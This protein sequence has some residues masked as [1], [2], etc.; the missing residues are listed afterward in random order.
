MEHLGDG[1][2]AFV[3]EVPGRAMLP[4]FLWNDGGTR[5]L[6]S[7][8]AGQSDYCDM[9]G[10]ADAFPELLEAIAA[11]PIRFDELLLP[12]L[13]PGSAL[14]GPVPRGWSARE[15]THEV[16]PVL[17]L[18]PDL[19]RS[20]RRKVVHDR[21]RAEALGGVS[22][23]LVEPDELPEALV[24]LFALHR[25]RWEAVG[26]PGMLADPRVEAFLRTAASAL[27][28]A[29]LLRTTLVRHDGRIV[30]VLLGFRD[31]ECFHSYINGVDLT[32]PKQSFGTL[33]FVCLIDA[34]VREGARE[35]HFLRGEEPY[36]YR[37]GARPVRTVRRVL[38]LT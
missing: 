19:S 14:L 8:G 21:H 29:G 6:V 16:C 20:E 24:A 15:E 30:A 27:A 23:A 31:A 1:R 5:R 12:D 9:V 18:P 22:A 17:A 13:R 2:E 10:E 4:L 3:A 33:A 11:G 28:E 7:V 38:R 36:K 35:L 25:A 34:A 37:W 26:E 32:V